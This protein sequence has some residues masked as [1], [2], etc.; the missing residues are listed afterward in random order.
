ET[1]S[2]EMHVSSVVNKL[3][4][5]LGILYK[6]C[7]N[8]TAS[9]RRM[10]YFAFTYSHLIYGSEIFGNAKHCVIHPLQV[11]PKK[12]LRCLQFAPKRRHTRDIYTT[13]N[14]LPVVDLFKFR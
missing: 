6:E 1:L 5:Q 10:L 13:Y 11:A 12:I 7:C 8:L 3:K 2:W 9:C 14:T 4:C